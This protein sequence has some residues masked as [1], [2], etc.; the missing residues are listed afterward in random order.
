M[1][2][3][4]LPFWRREH[5]VYADHPQTTLAELA[6]RWSPATHV[7]TAEPRPCHAGNALPD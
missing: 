1:T 2:P 4:S 7:T 6:A 3:R 5:P